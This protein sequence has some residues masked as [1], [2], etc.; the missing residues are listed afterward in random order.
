MMAD[1]GRKLFQET[2]EAKSGALLRQLIT[3]KIHEAI[4]L[5]SPELTHPSEIS[6]DFRLT[7]LAI[8]CAVLNFKPWQIFQAMFAKRGCMHWR[9]PY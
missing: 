4:V 6:G 8:C 9:S 2:S 3:I 5:P 7:R 1:L